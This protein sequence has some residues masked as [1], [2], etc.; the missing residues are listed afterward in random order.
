MSS[1]NTAPDSTAA[2]FDPHEDRT[3]HDAAAQDELAHRQLDE[4]WWQIK[5]RETIEQADARL[6]SKL[7]KNTA[8]SVY[9]EIALLQPGLSHARHRVLCYLA[10]KAD[11]DLTNAF[12][13]HEKAAAMLG[14]EPTTY[15]V[16]LV[17][18]RKLGWIKT[19]EFCDRAKQGNSG[20]QFMIPAKVLPLGDPWFG[21]MSFPNHWGKRKRP[22]IARRKG[23]R[24]KRDSAAP[25]VNPA[26]YSQHNSVNNSASN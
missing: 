24:P 11:P 20:V 15:N 8:R 14:I 18:L 21:P 23:G 17:A 5:R 12:P 26:N 2:A 10:S 19:H 1:G 7:T 13:A 25:V 9:L 6:R 16:H 3:P 4:A 22:R